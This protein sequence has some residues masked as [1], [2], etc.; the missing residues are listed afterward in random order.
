[1]EEPSFHIKQFFIQIAIVITI[2]IDMRCNGKD[3]GVILKGGE[4]PIGTD[5]ISGLIPLKEWFEKILSLI[6]I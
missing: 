1:M 5:V 3:S 2:S 6:H 4:H